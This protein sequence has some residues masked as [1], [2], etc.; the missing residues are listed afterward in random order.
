MTKI[1][2]DCPK[3]YQIIKDDLLYDW[4][5]QKVFIQKY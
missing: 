4:G 1:Q 2:I 5:L 3:F